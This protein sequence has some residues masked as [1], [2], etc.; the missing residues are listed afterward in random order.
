MVWVEAEQAIY[1]FYQAPVGS[2]ST[3][4]YYTDHFVEGDPES[5][6]ALVP[7]AGLYQPI[8]GFGL[9]WRATPQVRERLGWATAPEAGFQTWKQ[10]YRGMGM[11]NAYTL[12]EGIDGTIYHMIAMGS[13]WEI[14]SP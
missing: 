8:R 3:Y 12:M 6:P 5:D 7:P 2:Y 4:E 14:Y 9:V 13:V 11:H 10:G 1:V